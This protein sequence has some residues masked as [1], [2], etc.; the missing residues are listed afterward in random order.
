MAS[1]KR[2]NT[3]LSLTPS[4]QRPREEKSTPYRN[5][6]YKTLL[7]T[8]GSFMEKSEFGITNESKILCRKL[9]DEVQEYPQDSLLG[10]NVFETTCSKIADKNESRVIQDI[11]R[12][13]V[14]SAESLATCGAKDLKILTESVNEGWNNSIPLTGTRPQ[15]DYSVGFRREAFTDEQLHRIAPFVGDFLAGDQSFFMATYY[16][17]FPFLTCEV[18]CGAA[19]LNVADSQNAHGMTLAVRAIVELFRLVKRESELNRQILAFS[20]SHDDRA[21]RIYGH[22]P[23]ID[24][25][26]SG[27]EPPVSAAATNEPKYYR[28]PIREFSFA[29]LEGHNKWAAYRFTKNVYDTWMP[30]HFKRICSAIDQLPDKLDFNVHS[31]PENRPS[32]ELESHRLSRPDQDPLPVVARPPAS[33]SASAEAIAS[34]EQASEPSQILTASTT[35]APSTDALNKPRLTPTGYLKEKLDRRSQENERLMGLL[36][37]QR[38]LSTEQLERHGQQRTEQ[39]EKQRQMMEEKMERQRQDWERQ[40]QE[41]MDLLKASMPVWGG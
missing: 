9:L 20:I 29:E 36:E 23:V 38:Q 21:V 32:Q 13:I 1:R 41:I 31:V 16:M 39:L 6:R 14:P 30:A 22:Y 12:L 17:Y 19:A 2:S 24:E 27:C 5:P 34:S 37:E 10:D 18:K 40:K 4:D 33:A 8:K 25:S 35:A 11:S 28:H 3:P 15:P 26:P 7:A